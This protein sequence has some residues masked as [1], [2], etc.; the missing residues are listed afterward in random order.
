[1]PNDKPKGFR[2]NLTNYG[3]RDFALYLRRS[4]ARSM[5]YSLDMVAKI[6]PSQVVGR[7]VENVWFRCVCGADGPRE[8]Q[9]R[10]DH[11]DQQQSDLHSDGSQWFIF[12]GSHACFQTAG[13]NQCYPTPSHPENAV[14]CV[15]RPALSF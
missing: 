14:S 2:R 15:R 11:S 1:M 13:D 7:N 12:L 10:G 8:D 3:D 4:F 9:D 5:G 6:F